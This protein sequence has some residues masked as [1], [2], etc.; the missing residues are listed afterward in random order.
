MKKLIKPTLVVGAATVLINCGTKTNTPTAIP[1]TPPTATVKMPGINLNYMDLT[2]RPQDDFFRYVNGKWVDSTEIPADKTAWGSFYELREKTDADVLE[3]LKTA[4]NTMDW[5]NNSDE[6]KVVHLYK[7]VLDIENRNRQ[8]AT[9]LKPLLEKIET[10]QNLNTLQTYLIEMQPQGGGGFFGMGIGADAKD[11]NKNRVSVYPGSLGL[12][13]RDYYIAEDEDSKEKKKKYEEHLSLM[14]AFLNIEESKT[15]AMA[16]DIVKFETEMAEIRLDKVARRDPNKTYNPMTVTELQKL[17][18]AINWNA[19]FAGVGIKNLDT[20]DVSDV[21]YFKGLNTLLQKSSPETW[22]SYAT[23]TLLDRYASTLSTNIETAQWEFFS[24][25][26]SGAKEQEPLEKRALQVVN[27]TLGEALGKLYVA[28]VFPQ[29]AKDAALEMIHNIIKAYEIRINALTWMDE[30]TKQ[31]AIEKLQKITIKVGYPD[32]W[33]DYS[34][35]T[36]VDVNEG[37]TYMG[38]MINA[39]EWRFK[40]DLEKLSK[41][42]DKTEWYMAPQTVNAYYNPSYNEIVFPAAILQPPF[43]DFKADAAINYGGMGAVIGHEISHGFDDS[44]ADYDAEGNL[45]NWWT[46]KDLEQFNKLGSLLADQYSAIEV[47]PGV[48][49]NGK[50]TLGENI[51][52]L[53]GVNAAYDGLQMHLNAHGDPGKIDG[54]T[55]NQRFFINWATVWRSKIREDALKTRIKTDPHSPGMYRAYQP[56]LNIDAFYQAFDIKEGDKLFIPKSDRVVIW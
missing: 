21:A 30:A 2:V 27:G 29:E 19:Y 7:A 37:G 22:K 31:K 32:K 12:P 41:P 14:L 8:G 17:T 40:K 18:P 55:Q 53:G 49:I 56:L 52:D 45:I 46:E 44:G 23:W 9:P 3:I 48:F 13:D 38:N 10:I 51:G 54:Y 50:F 11:S 36:I 20:V 42:V 16:S 15:K 6:G 4:A 34:A 25:T 47:L 5:P 35:L 26:L 39:R 43:F 1:E 24:K 33:K 28:A